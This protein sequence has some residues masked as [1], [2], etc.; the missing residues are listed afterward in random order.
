MTRKTA[1]PS[2]APLNITCVVADHQTTLRQAL[3]RALAE[4][5]MEV[6]RETADGADALAAIEECAPTVAILGAELPSLTGVEVAR[7]AASRGRG[8]AVILYAS[9]GD[10]GALAE[11]LNA[12]A[13]GFVL[14]EAPVD[15]LIRA[16]TTVAAGDVYVDAALSTT[17]KRVGPGASSP[18]LSAREQ[19]I[20]SLLAS[21]MKTKEIAGALFISP[22]TVRTYVRRAMEKLDARTR[23]QAV[24]LAVRRSLIP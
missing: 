14:R 15:E 8:T 10:Q 3:A 24:A 6:A 18:S 23:T 20:L 7:R 1:D 16:V 19:D 4:H 21:G 12:G 13:R 5:G 22:E 11:A 2:R 17:S 9:A